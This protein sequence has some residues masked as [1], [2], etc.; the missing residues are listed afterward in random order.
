[1][2]QAGR[3]IDHH[4]NFPAI[5][6]LLYPDDKLSDMQPIRHTLTARL[7]NLKM[8]REDVEQLVSLFERDCERIVISDNKYRYDSLD[9]MK[10]KAGTRI[11]SLDISGENPGI[12]FLFNQIEISKIGNPPLQGVYN[13]L[14]T[15]EITDAADGVFY[16][17]KD[18]VGVYQRPAFNR[19]WIIPTIL[20]LV[21]TFWFAV[22]N[23]QVNKSGQ[24]TDLLP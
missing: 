17:I 7:K 11:K 9:E 2:W 20:G 22:H 18:F 21:G 24:A 3:E 14:R 8:Y 5:P 15:E 12:R 4:H 10:A 19:P 1:M 16:K 6:N 23:S 13:E